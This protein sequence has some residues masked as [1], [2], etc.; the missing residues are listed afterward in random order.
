MHIPFS[1]ALQS[2]QFYEIKQALQMTSK[3][4]NKELSYF[5]LKLFYLHMMYS[6]LMEKINS[7]LTE[8][9]RL[10]SLKEKHSCVLELM[11]DSFRTEQHSLLSK[12]WSWLRPKVKQVPKYKKL[13]YIQVILRKFDMTAKN[14]EEEQDNRMMHVIAERYLPRTNPEMLLLLLENVDKKTVRKFLSVLNSDCSMSVIKHLIFNVLPTRCV[15]ALKLILLLHSRS[16]DLTISYDLFDE[17]R[18]K[19][20]ANVNQKHL[21]TECNFIVCEYC[22]EILTFRDIG[23]RPR[24]FGIFLQTEMMEMRCFRDDSAKLKCLTCFKMDNFVSLSLG[25][26]DRALAGLCHGKRSCFAS[27]G[28]GDRLCNACF[29]DF[30]KKNITLFKINA[31]TCL[32]ERNGKDMCITCREVHE[33]LQA[34]NFDVT[35]FQEI[36]LEAKSTNCA[37]TLN[38]TDGGT[39]K[40]KGN[41][42][43]IFDFAEACKKRKKLIQ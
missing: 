7:V 26:P 16:N 31:N 1:S 20:L 9:L 29:M 8:D 33:K 10:D 41:K 15:K 2:Y 30:N 38:T 4:Q 28:Y 32:T 14:Y 23:K 17:L 42:M 27:V 39:R 6:T 5:Q 18:L 11:R 37:L 25:Q 13:S 21:S 24:S 40:R 43:Y 3:I 34:D 36:K 35:S 19:C 22:K 12:H